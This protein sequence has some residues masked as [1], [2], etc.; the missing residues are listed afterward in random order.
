MRKHASRWLLGVI[1]AIII[2]VFVFTFGFNKGGPE[3]TIAQV[4]PYKISAAE[5]YKAYNRMEDF[6]RRLYGDK[7]D[8]EMRNQLKLKEMV[9][10]QLVD[11]YLLLTEAEDMG[12]RVSRKEF[13]EYLSGIEAFKRKGVFDRDVYSEFLR[14]NNLDPKTF[15]DGERQAMVLDKLMTII[16]DNNGVQTDEPAAYEAYLRERGQIRLSVG[17]F[18]PADYRDKVTVDEKELAALYEREKEMHRSEN[19]YHVRYMVIDGKSGV[20]DDQAYMDL[21]KSKDMPAYGKSKG[22]EVVDLGTAKESD[23]TSRFAGLKV[24]DWL[25]GLGKGEVSLPVRSGDRSY[26]FQMVDR[27][28]GKP[29]DRAEAMKAIRARITD[30]K[31]KVIARIKAEDAIKEKGRKFSRETGYL[32]KNSPTVPGIGQL[33]RESDGVLALTKGQTYEKPVE[34]GGRYYVFA[35]LDE[36]QPDKDQWEKEKEA[37]KRFFAATARNASLAAFKE[38]LKRSI[39]VR[40]DW[41]EI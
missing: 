19:M 1:C 8:E 7:F 36:K 37:Y 4:G 5:Y 29:L 18:D 40:V 33:P 23:I 26:I 30:E 27:T 14:R 20:K 16:Q 21:L 34:I 2:V 12:V 9:M 28:D 15:E 25:K 3:K 32:A 11:R 41:N 39:K 31:A 6:Y 22:I 24:L 38:D 17:V 10:N 35:Y 13:A